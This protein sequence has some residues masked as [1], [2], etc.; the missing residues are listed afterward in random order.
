MFQTA[1]RS[2]KNTH[3]TVHMYCISILSVSAYMDTNTNIY[4][5][6][7]TTPTV[8][9]YFRIPQTWVDVSKLLNADVLS[10]ETIQK[11]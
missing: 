8:T 5:P 9:Y 2:A 6:A 7:P 10:P 4:S 1:S 3:W 11:Y